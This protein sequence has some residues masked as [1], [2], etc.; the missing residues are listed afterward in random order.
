MAEKA[1]FQEV[2][3]LWTLLLFVFFKKTCSEV[4]IFLQFP[5]REEVNEYY[6]HC[7]HPKDTHTVTG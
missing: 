2:E 1:I 7:E 3:N 6:R 5:F 4:K